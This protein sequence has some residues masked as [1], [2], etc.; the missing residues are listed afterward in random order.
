MA[1]TGQSVK[2]S[3]FSSSPVYHDLIL[4]RESN[5]AVVANLSISLEQR[6]IA[7]SGT[8]GLFFQLKTNKTGCP[9]LVKPTNWPRLPAH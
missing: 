7:P 5:W 2:K 8:Y 6:I 9:A 4:G 3:I 1:L